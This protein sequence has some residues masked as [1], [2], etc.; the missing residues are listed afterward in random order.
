MEI[1]GYNN[2][3]FD[4]GIV[5]GSAKINFYDLKHMDE[6]DFE[7]SFSESE[8]EDPNYCSLEGL[9]KINNVTILD[10]MDP[11]DDFDEERFRKKIFKVRKK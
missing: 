8:I 2:G 3:K 5:V 11:V 6:M 1:T 4:L 7:G 9:I 10:D